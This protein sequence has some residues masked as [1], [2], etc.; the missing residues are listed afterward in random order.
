[1]A[2]NNILV[3]GIR[4][5]STSNVKPEGLHLRWF[6]PPELGFPPG[7]F[8]IYRREP[9]PAAGALTKL[10]PLP[11]N[12]ILESGLEV[13]N[14]RFVLPSD[15]L[16]TYEHIQTA[17]RSVPY[18]F[19]LH[20]Q[21]NRIL[22]IEFIEPVTNVELTF[23][24][25]PGMVRA[26]SGERDVYVE[27]QSQQTYRIPKRWRPESYADHPPGD[28]VEFRLAADRFRICPCPSSAASQVGAADHALAIPHL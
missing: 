27:T 7:G 2:P 16:L 23:G 22:T 25:G 15:T 10:R 18:G 1:M 8:E 21:N 13:E 24:A 26:F 12:T 20:T 17:S 3:V 14:L 11:D 4:P 28:P 19:R 6:F 5:G 9:Q